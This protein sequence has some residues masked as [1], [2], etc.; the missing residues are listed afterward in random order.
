MTENIS[1][2]KVKEIEENGQHYKI[3]YLGETLDN[4]IPTKKIIILGLTGVG[5][6]TISFY[7]IKKKFIECSPTISLDLGNYKCKVNGKIIQIQIWDTCGND[8]FVANTPNLF[9]N[10]FLAIIVYAIDN[11]NSFNDIGKWYNILRKNCSCPF[12]YLIGNKNDLEEKRQVQKHEA[13]KLVK[14][15][16]F[17]YFMETS[18]LSGCN[19]NKLLDKI[20]IEIYEKDE[21]ES[22]NQGSFIIKNKDDLCDN[23]EH[24]KNKNRCC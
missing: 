1:E 21:E 16:K 24:K 18:A 5:K 23:T 3:E 11:K 9:N 6:S 4:T 19:I 8:E 22:E 15:Y 10:S 20:A 2:I 7:L 13:F 14:D 17:N 12:I